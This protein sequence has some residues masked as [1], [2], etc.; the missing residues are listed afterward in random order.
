ML[1]STAHNL[2]EL[3]TVTKSLLEVIAETPE[4]NLYFHVMEFSCTTGTMFLKE[5]VADFTRVYEQRDWLVLGSLHLKP[6]KL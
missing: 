5:A 4:K 6:T 1:S 3:Y 2:T